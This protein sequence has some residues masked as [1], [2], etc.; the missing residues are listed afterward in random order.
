MTNLVPQKILHI[1]LES[2]SPDLYPDA[3]Y[4]S[5][6]VVFWWHRIPLGHVE[7][8]RQQLPLSA[9]HLKQKAVR[10]IA[11]A[12]AAHLQ[13]HKLVL[14][15]I[16]NLITQ[17]VFD[18]DDV[19]RQ[20]EAPFLAWRQQ[21]LAPE[22]TSISVV[23]CTRDRPDYVQEC[24]RSLRCLSEPPDEIVV[25]DNAPSSDKTQKIV[26]Q[27]PG[28]KYV[29][30]PRPGLDFARNAG[31]QHS[32][33]EL[34]AYTDDDVKVHPDWI[35]Q[36]RRAFR[37]PGVMAVTGLVFAAELD[38]R[39]QYVFEKHWSF[40]RGY[41]PLI[42]DQAYFQKYRLVG[43]PAWRVGAGANMAF[44]R[45]LFAITGMFDERL[46]VG[47]A[48]C[49]GDSEMW[50]RVLAAGLLCRYDPTA[51]VHH[52]HRREMAGLHHQ[53]FYYM[54]GHVTELLIRF[55]RYSHW[56]NLV[57]LALLPVY[58]TY[59]LIFGWSRGKYRYNTILTEILGCLSGFKFY[60]LS[61]LNKIE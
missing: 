19:L 52:S 17:P 22:S 40:N 3:P 11:P 54:R 43:V 2:D 9:K 59:L 21:R 24:L 12:I 36:L 15:E 23:I 1:A 28:I 10:I 25:V 18:A 16:T 56:G 37:E 42:Y 50:Y 51:V 61:K 27:T 48:G 55:E 30:E 49:S 13:E 33:S 31:M 38:T 35:L 57:R 29:L 60:F 44:R 26:A 32:A 53:L 14:P 7:L 20:W 8:T 58:F 34:I 39:S 5:W 46:D 45:S 4:L 47:A 41:K 6:Y